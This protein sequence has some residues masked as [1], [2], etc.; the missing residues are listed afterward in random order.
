M[1]CNLAEASRERAGYAKAVVEAVLGNLDSIGYPRRLAPRLFQ[2]LWG[3]K[4]SP[5]PPVESARLPCMPA[6]RFP[7]RAQA[8]EPCG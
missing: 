8:P 2:C 1:T 4:D 7:A 3:A 6:P 5:D